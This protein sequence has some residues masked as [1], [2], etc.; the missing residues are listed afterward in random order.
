M[1][2]IAGVVEQAAQK[3]TNANSQDYFNATVMVDGQAVTMKQLLDT[4]GYIAV[5]DTGYRYYPSTGEVYNTLP[6]DL[7]NPSNG[8]GESISGL[9]TLYHKADASGALSDPA[10]KQIVSSL[11]TQIALAQES[12]EQA[13]GEVY[14]GNSSPGQLESMTASKAMNLDSSGI[15]QAGNGA[16][17]GIHCSSL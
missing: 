8:G 11:T 2:E 6:T 5:T 9:L 1:A 16:D 17:S 10:I 12:L 3:Y 13:Q 15:C 7:L 14:M 4:M